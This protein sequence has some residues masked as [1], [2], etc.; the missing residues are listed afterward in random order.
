MNAKLR[1]RRNGLDLVKQASILC[2]FLSLF[3]SSSDAVI[4]DLTQCELLSR[5]NASINGNRVR[6]TF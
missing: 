1:G 2:D 5:I 3:D 6:L 4:V